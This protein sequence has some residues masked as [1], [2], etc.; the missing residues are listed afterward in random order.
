MSDRFRLFREW[1]WTVAQCLDTDV[2]TQGG[3]DD[4]A[5]ENAREALALHRQEPTAIPGGTV[6]QPAME[7]QDPHS[8]LDKP[9]SFRQVRF[10]LEALGFTSI[11]QKGNH[12][13]FVKTDA[14]CVR[15]AILPHFQELSVSVVKSILRQAQVGEDEFEKV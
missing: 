15:T 14:Q 8:P 7:T 9:L 3:N 1:H 5:L 10:K 12:A 13:K 2:A 4:E 6:G 11:Y